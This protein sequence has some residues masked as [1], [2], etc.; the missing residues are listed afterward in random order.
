MKIN[1]FYY[2]QV[3][4]SEAKMQR[5]NG[6]QECHSL[7]D[8]YIDFAEKASRRIPDYIKSDLLGK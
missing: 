4:C 1:I 3:T 7:V 2:L 5:V 8:F 6:T